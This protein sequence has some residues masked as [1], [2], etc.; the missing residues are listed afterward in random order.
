MTYQALYREWR[1]ATFSEVSGQEHIKRTLMN[2]LKQH[3]IPHALLFCGPRGTGKTSMAKILARAVNCGEGIS[4]E[5]CLNCTA[6]R[7]IAN[8]T[9][10]DVLEIDAAS[11]RGIDE[12]RE[13]REHVKFAPS[14][15]RYKVYIIDEVHMLTTE[16]F[17]ALLKTLE[18]PPSYVLFILATTEPHKLPATIISR[19]QRFDFRRLSQ[20][21]IIARL[22]E[23]SRN[24]GVD[25]SMEAAKL[26]AE[27]AQGGMRDALG[28]LEQCMSFSEDNVSLE[29]VETVTGSVPT[30]VYQRLLD[31]L[32]QGD[33]ARALELLHSELTAG[34]E[35][36]QYL[37]SYVAALRLLLLA[38]HSPQVLE[39]QG[40]EVSGLR[41]LADDIASYLPELILLALSTENDMRY[42][43]HPRL[44]LEL[45]IVRQHQAISGVRQAQPKVEDEVAHFE[46]IMKPVAEK[47]PIQERPQHVKSQHAAL[48]TAEPTESPQTSA[49][50]L[51]IPALLK[52]WPEVVRSIKQRAPLTGA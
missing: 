34:R 11:N 25:L 36:G 46:N 38:A 21:S 22:Q 17:N 18:E 12:I 8:N 14:E 7:D 4:A 40:Y 41:K 51:T 29:T 52:A 33:V 5:P 19:C 43:G 20:D 48:P 37:R 13:L 27:Q 16:A 47:R 10:M 28:M 42:G 9:S 30:M 44:H 3:R 31:A 45:L 39:L 15:L 32:V 49:Q 50:Q 6:C 35:A 24:K 2:M 1:P 26:I 23:I